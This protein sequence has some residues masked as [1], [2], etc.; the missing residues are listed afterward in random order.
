[1]HDTNGHQ[2]KNLI[3]IYMNKDSVVTLFTHHFRGFKYSRTLWR[4][5]ALHRYSRKSTF[6]CECGIQL[7]RIEKFYLRSVLFF[8]VDVFIYSICALECRETAQ[9]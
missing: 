2:G 6:I 5:S 4:W 7:D 1:M 8:F 9:L 3:I